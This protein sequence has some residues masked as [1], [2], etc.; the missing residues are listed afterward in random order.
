MKSSQEVVGRRRVR[1]S[2]HGVQLRSSVFLVLFFACPVFRRY[3][4]PLKHL[5]R[6]GKSFG[7]FSVSETCEEAFFAWVQVMSLEKR[8]SRVM[9]PFS[10]ACCV[11]PS[12]VWCKRRVFVSRVFVVNV[13]SWFWSHLVSLLFVVC[14][15]HVVTTSAFS[16]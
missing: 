3:I 6:P 2:V 12:M 4:T 10:I 14:V 16:I 8:W 5:R 7:R 9:C 1:G 13:W 11:F 15:V